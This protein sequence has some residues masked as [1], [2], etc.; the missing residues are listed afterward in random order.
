MLRR[1]VKNILDRIN[2]RS[3]YSINV[4]RKNVYPLRSGLNL[5]V[6]AGSTNIKGFVNLDLPSKWYDKK[7]SL[8]FVKYD[9]RNDDLPYEP[10]SVNNIYCSHVIEHIEEQFVQRFIKESQRVL[11]PGGTLRLV[12]PDAAFLWEVSRFNNGYWRWLKQFY[13]DN[14][15]LE[16][17][18]LLTSADCLIHVLATR[19]CRFFPYTTDK[20]VAEVPVDVNTLKFDEPYSSQLDML[21]HDLQFDV[22]FV[23]THISW[24]DFDKIARFAEAA[25]F[26]HIVRS[27]YQGSVSPQLIGVDIDRTHPE[28]SL[29]VDCVK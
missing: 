24:W 5:N 16:D 1:I 14:S 26:R 29:Y 7:K 18:E 3:R 10:N 23:H 25:G 20:Q 28:M 11:Q 6:G 4:S 17:V 15:T 21:T 9:I 8:D 19:K 27:K 2:E 22:E 12:C 13:Q